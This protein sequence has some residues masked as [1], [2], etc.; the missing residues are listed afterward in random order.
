MSDVTDAT[1]ATDVLD[2]SNS[3]PVVVDLWAEWC[4]PC[5]SLGPILEKVIG[6]TNG[7]VELVKVDVDSNPQTAQAFQ[8]QSIPAVY[9]LKDGKIVDGFVG[10]QGEPQVREFVQRLLPSEQDK[11]V[12]ALIAKGDEASLREVLAAFPDHPLALP[13][14]ADLLVDTGR[15]EEALELLKRIPE[16]AQTRQ[17]A[18]RAR[19][20]EPGADD[21][22]ASLDE[23]LTRVKGDEDVRQQFL[24]LLEVLGPDHP[25]TAD[26]R[27]RLA[28]A[29]F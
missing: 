6:E 24:D 26:Y 1:F 22:L 14:L 20:G 16:T 27:R 11:I 19:T 21:I 5:K 18:A 28:S 9:A 12:A 4:G 17:I 10:A 3:V 15:A 7:A 2:R 29:L 8:V 13:Q 25:S 23:L